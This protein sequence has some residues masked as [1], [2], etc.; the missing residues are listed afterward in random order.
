MTHPV[1]TLIAA[2]LVSTAMAAAEDRPTRARL[3]VG[4]RMFVCC[5]LTVAGGSWL[6]RL[7]HG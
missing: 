1:F 3:A 5:L 2:L 4:A 6:M 7:I